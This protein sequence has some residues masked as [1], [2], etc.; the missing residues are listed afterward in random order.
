MAVKDD[1]HAQHGPVFQL[2]RRT[3]CEEILPALLTSPPSSDIL[4]VL[5]S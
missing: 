2:H 4:H 5:G 1:Q 3:W